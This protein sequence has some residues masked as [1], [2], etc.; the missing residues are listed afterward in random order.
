MAEEEKPKRKRIFAGDTDEVR[1][2]NDEIKNSAESIRQMDGASLNLANTIVQIGRR[3]DESKKYSQANVDKAKEQS[4]V[5]K[6]MLNVIV[7]Q[8][9]GNRI[10]TGIAKMRLGFARMFNKGLVE[11]N[12]TLFKN[13]DKSQELSEEEKKRVKSQKDAADLVSRQSKGM[14]T[15]LGS[16]IGI[17]GI[18][19]GILGLFKSFFALQGKIGAKFGAIGMHSET[20]KS[21][22]MESVPNAARIG[23][24][25]DNLVAVTDA[26]SSNF[27]F[28]LE[29]ASGLS[30]EI[31]DTATALG[32]SD[33]E[34]ASLFG[35]LTQ[36]AGVSESTATDFMKQTA[37]LAQANGVAPN[38]VLQDIAKSSETI[39][40]FTG[41][42]PDNLMKAAVMAKKLGTNLDTV[43]KIMDGMLNFQESIGKEI[44]A[45]ILLGKQL[46]FQKARELALNNDIE[47]A[48]KVVLGQLGSEEEFQRMNAIQ[49]KS[50]ADALGVDVATMAQMISKQEEARNLNDVMAEQMPLEKMIGAEALDSMAKVISEFKAIGAELMVTIG[51]AV[52][53]VMEGFASFVKEGSRAKVLMVGLAAAMIGF[54]IFSTISAIANIVSAFSQIPFGVGVPLGIAAAG[55]LIGLIGTAAAV[56]SSIGDGAFGANAGTKQ[57][58]TGE[59]E[60]YNLS[61]ND[62]VV[63]TP[64]LIDFLDN[65]SF[66]NVGDLRMKGTASP[67]Q[68][69]SFDNQTLPNVNYNVNS[70][71]N[72]ITSDDMKSS[73]QEVM[74]PLFRELGSKINTNTQATNE[75]KEV[76]KEAPRKLGEAVSENMALSRY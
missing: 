53:G 25:M 67:P 63:A 32:I 61:P 36:I 1:N 29:K 13:H 38:A 45:S 10:A 48:M 35:T 9:K 11:R 57:I 34:A 46:N 7:N 66:S 54:A 39:A 56:V 73:F 22:L 3:W 12:K 76:Q 17:F 68:M 28:S 74:N 27:G 41:T 33:S 75:L 21:N 14:A 8:N 52:I 47:G 20:L 26:L 51:P 72:Q 44:E 37:L 59:G 69:E 31:A 5:G 49:R 70:A 19:G 4:K 6:M 16:V 60:I 58:S 42:T 50:L 23:K 55:V 18:S 71:N 2:L 30:L 62:D 43:G 24:N 15:M 40:K 65:L 64:N